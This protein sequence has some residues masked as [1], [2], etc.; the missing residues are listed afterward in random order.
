MTGVEFTLLRRG[1]CFDHCL[2]GVSRD[3]NLVDTQRDLGQRPHPAP[4]AD[5]SRF[6]LRSRILK[7]RD[8]VLV[9]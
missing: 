9:L 7:L 4:S 6:E 3:L 8:E 1:G 2:T 5:G